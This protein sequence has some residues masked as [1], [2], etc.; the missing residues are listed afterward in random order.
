MNTRWS[1]PPAGG[2]IMCASGNP[3]S[4]FVEFLTGIDH[5]GRLTSSQTAIKTSAN[6]LFDFL[7][8]IERTA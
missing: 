4:L 8:G 6:L 5:S 3:K 2:V 7:H 1:A